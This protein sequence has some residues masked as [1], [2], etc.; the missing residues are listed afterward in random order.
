MGSGYHGRLTT[1]QDFQ[2]SVS[3]GTLAMQERASPCL[4]TSLS[5]NQCPG[6]VQLQRLLC[7]MKSSPWS[8][9]CK[10][11]QSM[12]IAR[13]YVQVMVH[14]L[15]MA[16][17]TCVRLWLASGVSVMYGYAGQRHSQLHERCMLSVGT[18]LST[19]A[20]TQIYRTPA[21]GRHA[22]FMSHPYWMVT[23][24]HMLQ[25]MLHPQATHMEPI[26]WLQ[27]CGG[28]LLDTSR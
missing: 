8:S 27:I 2:Q 16:S 1:P 26:C 14:E 20:S 19:A 3:R 9:K 15:S 18:G 21:A 17:L 11:G 13:D 22:R 10:H 28:V 23:L 6:S 24:A 7:T 25:H 5:Q 12:C 4:H